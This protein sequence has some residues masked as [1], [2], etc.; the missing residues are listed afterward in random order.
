MKKN[1]YKR[2]GKLLGVIPARAGSKG[3]KN[4]CLQRVNGKPLIAYTI[5]YAKQ[6][7]KRFPTIVTTDSEKIKKVA[8]KHG[9]YVPFLRPKSLARDTT[10]MLEVLHHA[11]VAYENEYKVKLDGIV[12]LD[13][14]APIRN[15]K[16]MLAVENKFRTSDADL[17]VAVTPS[18]RNPY[19]N[20]FENQSKSNYVRLVK[21]SKAVRRQDVPHVY[22]V[23]NTFWIFSRKAIIKK[24]RIPRKTISHVVAHDYIDIDARCDLRAFVSYVKNKGIC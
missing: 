3:L 23:T 18:R 24:E 11:L 22:D 14:T 2:N 16:D 1:N 21:R 10:G 9:A 12:L 8:E 17:V 7:E 4:K 20:M 15:K 6:F 19:F 5:E 13:P